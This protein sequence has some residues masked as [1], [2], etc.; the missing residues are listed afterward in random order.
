MNEPRRN[1]GLT[2]EEALA[3]LCRT[4]FEHQEGA[5][6]AQ[7]FD[8]EAAATR[9]ASVA[10][11]KLFETFEQFSKTANWNS[12]QDLDTP[13]PSSSRG[14]SHLPLAQSNMVELL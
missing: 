5:G 13:L 3:D 14:S 8:L 6:A 4:K 9:A 7:A 12:T 1:S 2:L 11:A 10:R